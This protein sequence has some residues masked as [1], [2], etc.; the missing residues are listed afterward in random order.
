MW[1]Y[2]LIA[3]GVAFIA[4]EG[5]NLLNPSTQ[6]PEVQSAAANTQTTAQPTPTQQ[7]SLKKVNPLAGRSARIKMDNRGHFYTTARMNGRNVKVLVDTG[8]TSVALNQA[9]ARKI[10]IRTVPSDFKYKVNTANGVTKA[11]VAEIDRIEIGRIVVENVR[12]MIVKD[13]SLDG[14]LLGMSFLGQLRKFEISNQTLVLQ[15]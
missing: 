11:A 10:G 15:Q 3:S 12:T 5:V 8:A 7:A 14:T 4:V 1:R 2:V 13:S 9:T 6:Q